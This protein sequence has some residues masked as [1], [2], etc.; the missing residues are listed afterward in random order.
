MRFDNRQGNY[1]MIMVD[2]EKAHVR[3]RPGCPIEMD[4]RACGDRSKNGG[5]SR[6]R[7]A[8]IGVAVALNTNAMFVRNY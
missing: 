3:I 6:T 7:S 1:M 8:P 4:L 5:R 2:G